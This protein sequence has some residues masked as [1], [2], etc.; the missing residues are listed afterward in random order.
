[1]S[2]HHKL[3]RIFRSYLFWRVV[4]AFVTI[5]IVMTLTFFILRLMPGNPIDLYIINLMTSGGLSYEEARNRA[6]AMFRINLTRPLYEQYFEYVSNVFR[7]DLG[8][9]IV[10]IGTP[11]IKIIAEFLPWTIFSVGIALIISFLLGI[12]IGT[13]MAYRR[14]S[15]ID[16]VLISLF[17]I[18]SAI[19]NYIIGL[20]FIVILGA[21]LKIVPFTMLRGAYSPYIKPGFTVEFIADIF[22]HAA[23]PILVYVLTTIGSWALTMRG[24]VISVLGEDY[25]LVAKVRG[26]P[27]RRIMWTYVG[28]NAILPLFTNLAISIGFIFGGS[29][30]VEFVFVYRGI[31]YRLW[32]AISARDYPVAQ[33]IFLIVTAAVVI[34]NLI[35]DL[36]YAI[37]D[38][39]VRIQ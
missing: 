4:R 17:S 5:L 16:S 12:F 36:I 32:E 18:L 31:G 14:G 37:L 13:F 15:K 10:S 23:F 9:S 35:A 2:L 28:R 7:G 29:T 8:H 26:L 20:L 6:L 19:P 21:Q 3:Y 34:A 22:L 1:M 25:V 24:S 39:R 38:P 11:V 33:G 30:L 27:E